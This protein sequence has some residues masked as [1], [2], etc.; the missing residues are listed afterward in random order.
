MTSCELLPRQGSEATISGKLCR[1][2]RSRVENHGMR[3]GDRILV[4]Q[5]HPAKVGADVAASVISNVLLWRGRTRAA[6][7]VR[8]V[9]PVVGSAAVLRFADL[10]ALAKTRRGRYV[11]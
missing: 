7:A 11:L 4:H 5:V 1:S 6:L 2:C 10:D 9:L 3:R 8:V